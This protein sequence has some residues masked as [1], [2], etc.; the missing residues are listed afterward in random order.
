MQGKLILAKLNNDYEGYTLSLLEE[1][2]QKKLFTINGNSINNNGP[3]VLLNL[4]PHIVYGMSHPDVIEKI[5]NRG[6]QKM[7]ST[8]ELSH[9]LYEHGMKG[10]WWKVQ[11]KKNVY[12]TSLETFYNVS[13]EDTNAKIINGK[14]KKCAL[15]FV[16]QDKTYLISNRWFEYETPITVDRHIVLDDVQ[17]YLYLDV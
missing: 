3:V 7:L 10:S 13:T 4:D 11:V 9:R 12:M 5:L 16:H 15:Q 6:P 17:D 8:K 1:S 2:G 14:H